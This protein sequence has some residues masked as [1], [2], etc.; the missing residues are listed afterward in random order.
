MLSLEEL[1]NLYEDDSRIILD[2][3]SR[4]VGKND[5]NITYVKYKCLL[6]GYVGWV[7]LS[8]IR[9]GS[10][11][12]MCNG[13]LKIT[14]YEFIR[15]ATDFHGDKYDYSL[16]ENLNSKNVK[17]ICKEH[18]V[19]EQNYLSHLSG[20][21]CPYCA[22]VKPH[23]KESV[24]FKNPHIANFIVNPSDRLL[25]PY[26]NKKILMRCPDCGNE[27][28]LTLNYISNRGD[29]SCDKCRDNISVGEKIVRSI[30]TSNNVDFKTEESFPWSDDRRY[31][32]YLPTMK[33]IIEVHGMQHY[34]KPFNNKGRS[35][36]EEKSND[37]YKLHMAKN[38]DIDNYII[39]DTSSEDFDK[40]FE[41]CINILS[42]YIDI[43]F[44][45]I[46]DIKLKSV[47]SIVFSICD[48][49][50]KNNV[51]LKEIGRVFSFH[52]VTISKYL[53]QGNSLGLCNFNNGLDEATVRK[54]KKLVK[55]D[56]KTNEVIKEYIN[57]REVIKENPNYNKRTLMN[58]CTLKTKLCY[59]FYWSYI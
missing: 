3:E 24:K 41:N 45:K 40:N 29:F 37:D 42:E 39:I 26:S 2:R 32:F 57:V 6:D 38:N 35:L 34:V 23:I 1:K 33:T 4:R 15:R 16:I 46:E 48:Y 14:L 20:R 51:D 5:K 11:C 50:N 19:F 28:L 9:S 56:I 47:K 25:P 55:I 49:Y 59:G 58:A 27:R 13:K 17:I 44:N 12:P 7:S 53:K 8:N 31:D 54:M 43:D 22:K 36:D 10:K 30:L 21:G 18:G 52:Q